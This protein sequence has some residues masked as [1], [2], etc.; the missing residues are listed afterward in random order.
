MFKR[1]MSALVTA[2]VA[3]VCFGTLSAC[4]TIAGVGQ[5]IEKGGSAIKN[6]A[7]EKR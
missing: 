5:D 7:K 3:S 2:A 6:E 1:L 4:N